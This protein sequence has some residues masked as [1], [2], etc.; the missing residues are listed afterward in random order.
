M[1]F[2]SCIEL[3]KEWQTLVAALLALLA[4]YLT[5]RTMKSQMVEVVAEIRTSV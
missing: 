5:I 1:S 3:L 4:A 2:S